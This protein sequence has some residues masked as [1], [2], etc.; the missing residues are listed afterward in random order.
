VVEI[1]RTRSKEVPVENLR[2]EMGRRFGT[3]GSMD[4]IVVGLLEEWSAL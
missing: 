4:F 2:R 3:E 1:D